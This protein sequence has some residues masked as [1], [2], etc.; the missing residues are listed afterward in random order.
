[1]QES[2]TP[3]RPLVL[4][5]G[6]AGYVGAVLVRELL[7]RG[8][9][10]RVLDNLLFGN[11]A[12]ADLA[13]RPGFELVRGDIRSRADLDR[14][15]V[16]AWAVV[17]LAGLVGDPACAL[18]PAYTVAVNQDSSGPIAEACR[19]AG[20]ERFLFA[21]TC[22]VYGA[23]G[24]D[25][26]DEEAR[27][28]PVSLYA[29]TNLQA[30]DLLRAGFAGGDTAL[31]IL[32]FA[33]IHGVSPRMRFDLVVNL[34]TA[35]ALARG[36]I[37]VHGGEQWR[38]Q[39]HVHDVARALCLGLERPAREAEGVFN[40]GADDQN[41]RIRD[42][43]QTVVDAFPGTRA[44][45]RDV[46]DPRSYRVRFARLRER[47]GFRAAHSVGDGVREVG[48]YVRDRAVDA[49][50]PRYHNVRSLSGRLGRAAS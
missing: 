11:A 41:F 6:G 22:S 8:H 35:R 38:P 4:V 5:T 15:T 29:E 3:S 49:D 12:L 33:T 17:H 36:A 34:L 18:D 13:G 1:V 25:W 48:A 27:T 32:R 21:S 23:A 47:W 14:A 30:E 31:S 10:V 2:A 37:E 50:D 42:L 24:D 46:R 19:A 39:V 40:I 43:A 26:L 28:A 45:V 9:A 16:E 20:V 44:E 7:A